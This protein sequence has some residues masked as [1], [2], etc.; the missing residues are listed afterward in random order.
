MFQHIAFKVT[1]QSL[2]S[3]CMYGYLLMPQF[4]I[5]CNFMGMQYLGGCVC[6]MDG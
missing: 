1:F 4:I 5:T 6:A 2:F 3:T